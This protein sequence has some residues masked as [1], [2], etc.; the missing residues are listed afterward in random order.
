M[1]KEELVEAVASK[2]GASKAMVGEVLHSIVDG[3][4]KSLSKGNK[5]AIPGLGVFV[6]K[7]RA[8][9]AGVNPRTGAKV[10][11]PAMKVPR[12]RAARALK[13]AVK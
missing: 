8:A 1:T 6:V 10:Q 4:T 3:M 11:I 2:T 9:R 13:D 12:F 7:Q 5:V